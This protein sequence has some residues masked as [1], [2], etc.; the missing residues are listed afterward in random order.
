MNQTNAIELI[1]ISLSYS[2]LL[3]GDRTLKNTFVSAV[4]GR[5][6]TKSSHTIQLS[7]LSLSVSHGER[8]GII[9]RN[10]SGKSTLLKVIAGVLSPHQGEVRINGLITSL[11]TIGVGMNQNLSCVEN[12]YLSGAYL[13]MRRKRIEAH[14]HEILD[15]AELVDY[16]DLPLYHL[17]TGM[18]ARLAF[19]ISTCQKPDIILI[20][21]VLAVGDI[22]F[23]KKAED[24]LNNL[25]QKGSVSLIVSH[26]LEY[27]KSCVERT[28]WL[29][30]GQ[31]KMDGDTELV[32]SRYQLDT[33]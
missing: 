32:V 27:L 23:R 22:A 25:Q 7:R 33:Q 13:G 19:A 21:E 17:S 20:D 12:I 26:D 1:D 10:G 8:V 5:S 2:Y 24:R 6:R 14:L 31:V 11:I 9:G 3:G 16:A 15:W 18:Q 4:I 29:S 28:I 30:E